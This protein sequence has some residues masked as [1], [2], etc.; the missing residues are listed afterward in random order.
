MSFLAGFS[1]GLM[2]RLSSNMEASRVS[3]A[4]KEEYKLHQ[5]DIY[6]QKMREAAWEEM[7]TKKKDAEKYKEQVAGIAD[8]LTS[9]EEERPLA[10]KAAADGIRL[11]G[12]N[13]VGKYTDFLQARVKDPTLSFGK[14]QEQKELDKDTRF[15]NKLTDVMKN[16]QTIR[17]TSMSA[18]GGPTNEVPEMNQPLPAPV[19]QGGELPP[20]DVTPE[21]ITAAGGTPPQ[22]AEQ[23]TPV[24]KVQSPKAPEPPEAVRPILANKNQ[25]AKEVATQALNE[26]VPA[27]F[28]TAAPA[29]QKLSPED[30]SAME[31]RKRAVLAQVK[32]E[33]RNTIL[34]V[35]EGRLDPNKVTSRT[36][37]KQVYN[38]VTQIDPTY[39][40][41]TFN[42]RKDTI[43]AFGT[44]TKI[45]QSIN[46]LKTVT[47]HLDLLDKSTAELKTGDILA[48]N[49]VANKL[50]VETGKTPV[51]VYNNIQDY[52]S[53]ELARYY[54]GGV[55]TQSAIDDVKKTM[56]AFNSPAQMEALI[57]TTAA[58]VQG[59][60]AAIDYDWNSRMGA[61]ASFRDPVGNDTRDMV[62]RLAGK[63]GHDAATTEAQPQ[64]P[65]VFAKPS[66]KAI[67][68]LKS[69][70]AMA[71]QFDAKFG[72]GAS[73]QYLG[74]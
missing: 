72:P 19:T 7:Q 69:S 33:F 38:Y 37:A 32:P 8:A 67:S 20:P 41:E 42:Q 2:N 62:A 28:D 17:D 44:N 46:A 43:K 51:S 4:K 71:A 23:P 58:L 14:W 68:M 16:R 50:G 70:P 52:L 30:I 56:G 73:T 11:F 27:F 5:Q 48:W 40:A 22:Q 39:T 36:E 21:E 25:K 1:T 35:V 63:M 53:F 45:G 55:P 26:G 18:D 65:T 12:A 3:E 10:V 34:G 31:E 54:M 47:N 9:S 61:M 59:K 29:V 64:Q 66:E 13:N 60:V 15:V 74:K 57:N 49:K 24:S 6:D